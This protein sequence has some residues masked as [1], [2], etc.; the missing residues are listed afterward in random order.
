MKKE[1]NGVSS[2]KMIQFAGILGS[3]LALVMLISLVITGVQIHGY[4]KKAQDAGYAN[5]YEA[6]TAAIEGTAAAG[7]EGTIDFGDFEEDEESDELSIADS[8]AV[9][10]YNKFAI[11]GKSLELPVLLSD[12]LEADLNYSVTDLDTR[13]ISGNMI[14]P[15][16]ILDESGEAVIGY[17]DI[18]NPFEVEK[19]ATE[20]YITSF[21]MG[22][23]VNGEGVVNEIPQI[24]LKDS[25]KGS[26]SSMEEIRELFGTPSAVDEASEDEPYSYDNW[27][28]DDEMRNV[29]II[30]YSAENKVSFIQ[31]D[32]TGDFDLSGAEYDPSAMGDLNINMDDLSSMDPSQLEEMGFE[33]IDEDSLD[34]ELDDSDDEDDS[35]EDYDDADDSDEELDDSEDDEDY[36]DES[37]YETDDEEITETVEEVTV[38]EE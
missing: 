15:A 12:F 22:N 2:E 38:E 20:C 29:L 14:F 21:T 27:Y 11:N 8:S 6:A 25:D 3:A 35:D 36:Y 24:T 19:P 4:N 7:S 23:D 31:I 37:D 32:Y 9:G 13:T 1:F 17:I 30:G 33:M 10:D 26:G 18:F 16:E 28:M 34:D 5:L